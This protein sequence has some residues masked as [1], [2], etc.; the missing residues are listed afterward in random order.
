MVYNIGGWHSTHSVYWLDLQSEKRIWNS[1]RIVGQV[2]FSNHRLRDATVVGTKIVYV[3]SNQDEATY[4][5]E[6]KQSDRNLEVKSQ[7]SALDYVRGCNSS[8]CT[9]NDKIYFFPKNQDSQ[10]WCLD[11]ASEQCSQFFS[12]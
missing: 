4:V 12:R 11:V 6:Q 7:F 3:G 5:L 1:I 10:V 9:H 8:F 2:D